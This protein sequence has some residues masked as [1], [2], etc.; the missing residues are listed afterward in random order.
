MSNSGI[1]GH[2]TKYAL[3]KYKCKPVKDEFKNQINNMTSFSTDRPFIFLH[4]FVVQ[5][6]DSHDRYS[7]L[8]QGF[9]ND[10]VFLDPHPVVQ[11]VQVAEV[12]DFHIASGDYY[13]QD[14]RPD[15]DR[16]SYEQYVF[17]LLCLNF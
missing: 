3:K 7:D 9:Q 13:V 15:E 5:V 6:P 10:L 14:M 11:V 4:A 2:Q 17:V 12:S 16:D 1:F 8:S